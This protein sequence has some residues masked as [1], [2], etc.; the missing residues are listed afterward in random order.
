MHLPVN[1]LPLD[2]SRVETHRRTQRAFF[3]AAVAELT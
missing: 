1:L 3:D 2:Q